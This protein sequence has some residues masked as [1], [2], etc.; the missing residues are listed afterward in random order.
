MYGFIAVGDIAFVSLGAYEDVVSP[1]PSRRSPCSLTMLNLDGHTRVVDGIGLIS[2]GA[3][4]PLLLTLLLY[5][6]LCTVGRFLT[7]C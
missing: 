4:S 5:S 6:V 2:C 3:E 7:L 1:S